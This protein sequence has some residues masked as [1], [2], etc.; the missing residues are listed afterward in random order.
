MKIKRMYKTNLTEQYLEEA[1]FSGK[2]HLQNKALRRMKRD[3][4]NE[5]PEN[6]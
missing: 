6:Q 1:T 3:K 5:L 2:N 4:I